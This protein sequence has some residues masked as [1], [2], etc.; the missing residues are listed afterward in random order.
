MQQS[1]NWSPGNQIIGRI[2]YKE[3]ALGTSRRK[4][5]SSNIMVKYHI[6][7][8]N[9]RFFIF[10]VPNIAETDEQSKIRIKDANLKINENETIFSINEY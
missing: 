3:K 4:Y 8:L 10:P 2:F 7:L 5:R 6:W 1:F 9:G